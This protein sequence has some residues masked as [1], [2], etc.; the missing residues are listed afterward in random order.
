MNETRTLARFIVESKPGDISPD[1]RH[2]A[3]RA[4]LNWMACA[5]GGARHETIDRALA[6]IE[7][8]MGPRHASLPGRSERVDVPHAAFLNGISSHLLDFDDTHAKAIHPSA[9]VAP[10]LLA[11]GEWKGISGADYVHAF[12]LGVE[13]ECRIGL[14]VYPE[15][16]DL[17]W[18][19][20]GTAGTF[21]AAAAIGKLVGLDE[22]QMAWA[23]GLSAAQAAGTHEVFGSMTKS[24][25]PGKAAQNGL[26]AALLAKQG[27]TSTETGIEGKHGFGH[28]YSTRFDPTVV[29]N[30]L[31]RQYE[32]SL[33]MYKAYACGLVTQGA[34]YGCIDLCRQHGITHDQI[35]SV[36]MRV[37][38]RTL[39]LT[40]NR[41]PR[42]GLEGKFSVY[43][44][45]AAAIVFG[46]ALEEQF[47]D[48]AVNDPRVLALRTRIDATADASLER[49][50]AVVTMKLKDGRTVVNNVEHALGTLGRPM[51]DADLE[52][53]FRGLAEPVI[54]AAKCREVVTLCWDVEKLLDVGVLARASAVAS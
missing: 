24:L 16:H 44:A 31:G 48:A 5:I 53:K 28:V 40:N 11:Y 8:F 17:G 18:H 21:G 35:E 36:G 49:T 52:A 39:Q 15:H 38:P 54:G 12:V 4:L 25:Q 46:N 47:S 50:Q 2:E 27:Y 37:G 42:N 45:C 34:I 20:T 51:S 14:S 32:L 13:A 33:N 43:H 1:V 26:M 23:F 3:S 30:D 29:T 7:P 6:A 22:Q 19:I 9:P 41:T 10:A